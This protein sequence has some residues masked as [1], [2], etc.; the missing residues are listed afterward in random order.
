MATWC[1]K[2]AEVLLIVDI[3]NFDFSNGFY[4][5]RL[6]LDFNFLSFEDAPEVRYKVLNRFEKSVAFETYIESIEILN[7]ANKT[8]TAAGTDKILVV[9]TSLQTCGIPLGRFFEY[10]TC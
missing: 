5:I 10:V 9:G 3:K 8:C 1:V 6:V 2:G 4:H 7:E